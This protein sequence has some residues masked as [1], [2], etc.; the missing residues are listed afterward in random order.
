VTPLALS[1]LPDRLAVCRLPADAPIPAPSTGRLWSVTRTADEVSV[2][3]PEAEAPAAGQI[4]PGW[5]AFK[6]AGPLDFSLTGILAAL[7]VPLA[8]ARIGLFAIST[9]DTDYLLVR[10]ADLEHAKA[11][12][13]AAGHRV[14]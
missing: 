6:V 11:A 9:Y 4:E 3:L 7:A 2:V 1:V 14:D 5:R 13:R 12:L 10:E 8:T